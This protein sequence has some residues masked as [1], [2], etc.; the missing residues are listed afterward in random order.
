MESSN[1]TTI[2]ILTHRLGH[3]DVSFEAKRFRHRAVA[4]RQVAVGVV[5]AAG[6]GNQGAQPQQ[7]DVAQHQTFVCWQLRR[8]VDRALGFGHVTLGAT[9]QQRLHQEGGA[10]SAV[11]ELSC[12]EEIV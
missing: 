4:I 9:V 12:I 10:G 1:S 8:T 2:P 7:P 6:P 3:R 5:I 11:R